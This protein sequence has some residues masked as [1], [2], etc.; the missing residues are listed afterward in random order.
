MSRE[1][2]DFPWQLPQSSN[3]GNQGPGVA[4]QW[5][6][7]CK[8][9]FW[10]LAS[11]RAVNLERA[12]CRRTKMAQ[13]RSMMSVFYSF[14]CVYWFDNRRLAISSN[15]SADFQNGLTSDADSEPEP[16]YRNGF[17]FARQRHG[18]FSHPTY[19][20]LVYQ[21]PSPYQ[22]P[23]D[24]G[25]WKTLN[26]RDEIRVRAHRETTG[27]TPRSTSPVWPLSL[28]NWN[29]EMCF[30]RVTRQISPRQTVFPEVKL[31]SVTTT[32]PRDCDFNRYLHK[33]PVFGLRNSLLK[34]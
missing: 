31:C 34:Q 17:L 8:W 9:R 5:T 2:W 7:V 13:F 16:G 1:Q 4:N 20:Y 32:P 24:Q 10:Q 23:V 12:G 26:T 15:A 25:S 19:G 27:A 33:Q 30:P 29:R 21:F 14:H 18:D 11:Y 22:V 3:W 6:R 28:G